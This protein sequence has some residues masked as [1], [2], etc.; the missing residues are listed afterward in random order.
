MYFLKMRNNSISFFLV[1]GIFGK[2]QVRGGAGAEG[3]GE[4]LEALT[5]SASARPTAKLATVLHFMIMSMNCEYFILYTLYCECLF[6]QTKSAYIGNNIL[7]SEHQ[8]GHSIPNDN[9]D[10]ESFL[11]KYFNRVPDLHFEADICIDQNIDLKLYFESSN[12]LLKFKILMLFN[13]LE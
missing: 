13:C 2:S 1:E 8:T 3:D 7:S 4:P 5:V 9:K 11:S 12:I 10:C 6:C